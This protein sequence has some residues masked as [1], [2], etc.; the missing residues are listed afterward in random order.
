MSS[1]RT[2]SETGV[3]KQERYCSSTAYELGLMGNYVAKRARTIEDP[4]DRALVYFLQQ[5]SHKEGGLE[6]VAEELLA[7]FPERIGTPL[8][9]HLNFGMDEQYTEGQVRMIKR[10]MPPRIGES[11]PL[12]GESITPEWH[13]LLPYLDDDNQDTL[14]SAHIDCPDS[15]PV[16]DLYDACCVESDELAE[17]LKRI[18]LDPQLSLKEDPSRITRAIKHYNFH[19]NRRHYTNLWNFHNLI[20]ALHLYRKS[21]IEL[22]KGELAQ[23]EIS[24]RILD[25]MDYALETKSFVIIEG[26]ERMGKS[27]TA[28][29]FCARHPGKAVYMSLE[30]GFDEKTFFRSIAKAIGVSS[31]SSL[32][33]IDMRVRIEDMLQQGDIVLVIDEAW[34]LW[35]QLKRV[36]AAPKRIDWL[37]LS[38]IDKGVPVVLISTP[39]FYKQC[40]KFEKAL[41]WNSRQLKGRVNLH[42]QLPSELSSQDLEAI[43]KHKLPTADRDTIRLLREVSESL[44]EY[45][46]SVENIVKRANYFAKKR[47]EAEAGPAE[48]LDAVNEIIPE[49]PQSATVDMNSQE[50]GV[51]ACGAP[52]AGIHDRCSS[53]SQPLQKGLNPKTQIRRSSIEKAVTT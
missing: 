34:T 8:M 50:T 45:V 3:L 53:I 37:R 49:D 42:E 51:S 12:N 36:R 39:Q 48:I 21:K 23:T 41:E 11:F 14:P 4:E 18:C 32:K 20:E 31:S 9:W 7:M 15:Y 47:G 10:E 24:Q 29:N 38:L 25:A 30:S 46:S 27:V 17:H 33:A 44:E 43:A 40:E 26:L 35:P 5:E 52:S 13:D 19:S 28:R 16:R 2:T 6:K 1:T 22:A